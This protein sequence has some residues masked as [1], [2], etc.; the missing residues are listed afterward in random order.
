[1]TRAFVGALAALFLSTAAQAGPV[2]YVLSPIV[3]RGV[4]K[5][6]Q[7]DVDLEGD[8]DGVTVLKFVDSFQG[9]KR[10][11]R[12]AEGFEVAGATAFTPIPDG[13]AKIDAQ[14]RAPLHI[15]YRV[16]SGFES[17]PTT[18]DATQT[19]PIVL[20][21]WFYV[22]GELLFAYPE[23]REETPAIFTWDAGGSGFHFASDLEA[24]A[25]RE[26][27]VN[28]VLQSV[29]IGSPRLRIT[30]RGDVRVAALGT[31]DG[32]DDAAFS[33]MAFR[34][35]SGE[36]AFWGD[37]PTPF[38]VT[39]APL[40]T[41]TI[42][43]YSGAGRGDAF[44]L[45]VG[46]TLQLSD[47]RRLLAH[48]YF[49]TWNADQLGRQA[50]QR[51]SAWLSEGFTDFYARRLLLRNGL[52][53]LTDYA[54]AWN[55]DLLGY[56]SSPVRSADEEM[57][58]KS[59]WTDSRLED[60]TYKRGALMAVLFDAQ[61]RREGKSLDMVM[62]EMRSLYRS[63][64]KSLLRAN[65][66]AAFKATSGRLPSAEID[67][68]YTRGE[69]LILPANAFACLALATVTQPIWNVGF[70]LDSTAETGIFAGVDPTGPAY[71][72]GLRNGMRRLKREGGV[73]NDSSV[74]IAYQVVDAAGR[75]RVIRYKP[76]GRGTVS[77]QRLTVPDGLTPAQ[78]KA[79]I[80][81]LGGI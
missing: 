29:A 7:V 39:L 62:R 33:E 23:D 50:K 13:G 56:G 20:P 14:P 76:E 32:Y 1:V 35:I 22:S 52:F 25:A 57:I 48:E 78:E 60:L 80:R 31:F 47:L 45:W 72:A 59:Y 40:E 58:A 77:F 36:R 67:R 9:D 81:T 6:L 44:A 34:V 65:F 21:D 68:Y 79:C 75:E 5:A 74:E 10:P 3:E 49:H 30:Q 18:Y 70:D 28:D 66:E 16:R 17:A 12:F 42:E 27:S 38:L 19:K 54:R 43:S 11:G 41:K 55:E 61:L 4:L 71:A 63:D 46:T 2:R 51:R 53:N 24:L 15:R 64:P 69:T 73:A 26:G 37:G 8:A